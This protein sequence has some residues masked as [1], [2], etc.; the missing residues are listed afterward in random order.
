MHIVKE[1][2]VAHTKFERTH[3][4]SVQF[5]EV[6][7]EGKYIMLQNTSFAKVKHENTLDNRAVKFLGRC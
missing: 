4:G 2:Q 7:K 3:K 5:Y 1:E 6:S